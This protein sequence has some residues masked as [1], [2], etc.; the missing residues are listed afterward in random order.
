MIPDDS[1]LK[2]CDNSLPQPISDEKIAYCKRY[3]E[4]SRLCYLAVTVAEQ[5]LL[6]VSEC[7]RIEFLPE[8]MPYKPENLQTWQ[9]AANLGIPNGCYLLG[10]NLINGGEIEQGLRW[11]EIAI[12]KGHKQAKRALGEALL[13]N[14]RTNEGLRLLEE[15][16][17]SGDAYACDALAMRYEEGE[18]VP[19]SR[20]KY[21]FYLERAARLGSRF[22]QDCLAADNLT[23][24]WGWL[25]SLLN[26]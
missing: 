2:H 24:S 21:R 17:N 25:R 7:D 19:K 22:A 15:A 11:L 18:G 26:I 4:L 5:A 12:S 9:E 6:G 20:S 3:M 1:T 10:Q 23:P 16:A 13:D 8:Y 14:G